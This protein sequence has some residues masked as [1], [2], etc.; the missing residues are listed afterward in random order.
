MYTDTYSKDVYKRQS[1]Y[2][3]DI[4]P[5]YKK[6]NWFSNLTHNAVV[7]FYFSVAIKFNIL[8]NK[9]NLKTARILP[10]INMN[11]VTEKSLPSFISTKL[12]LMLVKGLTVFML[13]FIFP[14]SVSF[15]LV[16]Y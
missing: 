9:R 14:A 11:I 1:L 15:F 4:I 2:I 10:H 5:Q 13:L 12:S 3:V 16:D 8:L 7:K 6:Q